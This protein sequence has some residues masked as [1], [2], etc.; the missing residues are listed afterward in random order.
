MLNEQLTR[1]DFFL[2]ASGKQRDFWLGQ[3]AAVGRINPLTYDADESLD[4]LI[5]GRPV[6]RDRRRR[7]VHTRPVLK[8]VVPGIGADDKVILWGGGIYNW[9][10]PLTLIRAVDKLRARVPERP[11]VLP[12]AQAPE[13]ERARDA[14]GGGDAGGSPTSSG[15]RTPTCSSTRSGCAYD[16]RQNYL[17]EADVGV[18]THLDHVETAFSFRTRILDY[19]WASLPVVTT[20]GDSFAD[21]ID[22]HGV[23]LT[24]PPGDVDALEAALFRLLDDTELARACGEASARFADEFR[25]S[26]VLQPLVEFCRTPRRAPDLV[27]PDMAAAIPSITPHRTRIPADLL[28]IA[29]LVRDGDVRTIVRKTG[30]RVKRALAG[31]R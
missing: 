11:A 21:V 17:L 31:G 23:G 7:R 29:R 2:C 15:S 4:E 24:V 20:G 13:P 26:K 8:G 12:R 16:D 19:L 9:F 6:R 18:S 3:L 30:G 14:D 5:D 25:W 27:D 10:D 28:A 22:A 1:G